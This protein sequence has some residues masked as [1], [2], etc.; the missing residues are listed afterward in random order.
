MA[1]IPVSVRLDAKIKG[2]IQRY[3]Q[4]R[5]PEW[6]AVPIQSFGKYLG[7]YVGPTGETH[8]WHAAAA[9]WWATAE[10]IIRARLTP[11]ASVFGYNCRAVSKLAYLLQV[12]T[13]P[14]ELSAI[15]RQVIH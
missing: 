7:F 15:E 13:P 3:L 12:L 8:N 10:L 9:D 4:S 2:D 5:V 1:I 11:N 14:K 6:Q